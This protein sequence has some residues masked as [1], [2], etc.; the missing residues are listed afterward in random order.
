MVP[1]RQRWRYDWWTVLSASSSAWT[2][3]SWSGTVAAMD[4]IASISDYVS[5]V[6]PATTSENVQTSFRQYRTGTR[7]SVFHVFPSEKHD[8][9]DGNTAETA[10]ATTDGRTYSAG[11]RRNARTDAAPPTLIAT[12]QHDRRWRRASLLWRSE[13][14]SRNALEN[15]I[16][17]Q[18][19]GWLCCFLTAP[20]TST[21]KEVRK[22]ETG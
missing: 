13:N 17:F 4:V 7:A 14:I 20:G 1:V 18:W 3:S 19:W 15:L 21:A 2:T 12:A 8:C 11:C 9:K 10:T 6:V 22:R 16:Q 5:H